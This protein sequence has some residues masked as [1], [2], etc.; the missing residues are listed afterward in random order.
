VFWMRA[1]NLN[2][3]LRLTKQIENCEVSSGNALH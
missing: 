1:A 2:A 3:R